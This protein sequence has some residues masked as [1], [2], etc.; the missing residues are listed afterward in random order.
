MLIYGGG[1]DNNSTF[2]SD[3]Q[4]GNS[5]SLTFVPALYVPVLFRG[6]RD[7]HRHRVNLIFSLL[8]EPLER[9]AFG[10]DGARIWEVR[11]IHKYSRLTH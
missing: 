2:R 7:I 4:V 9:L 3:I 6:V 1:S 8:L 5:K 11:W 10:G